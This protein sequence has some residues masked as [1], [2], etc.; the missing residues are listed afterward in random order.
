MKGY[1]IDK[2][3]PG[4]PY[5]AQINVAGEV[6]R[7]GSFETPEEATAAYLAAR[8]ASPRAARSGGNAGFRH[9]LL[10]CPVCYKKVAQNRL[11]TQHYPACAKRNCV[12]NAFDKD[13]EAVFN[14]VHIRRQFQSISAMDES[15]RIAP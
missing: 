12:D 9:D 6:R 13:L 4:R 3:C 2:R 10:R 11:R 1:T 7:L 15:K 5:I 8:A 14:D